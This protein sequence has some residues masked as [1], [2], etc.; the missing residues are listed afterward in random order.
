MTNHKSV[1]QTGTTGPG[2]S[3][4]VGV[5]TDGAEN[6]PRLRVTYG[7]DSEES[8]PPVKRRVETHTASAQGSSTRF[9]GDG[10]LEERV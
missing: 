1:L 5:T 9:L 10:V 3:H 8:E 6:T 4:R 7:E 2:R